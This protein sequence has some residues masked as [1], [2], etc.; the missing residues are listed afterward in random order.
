MLVHCVYFY[1][2]PEIT[3]AQRADFRRGLESLAGVKSAE[4]VYVGKP[5]DLPKRPVLDDTY[6]FG[7]TVIFKDTAGHNAYQTD[8]IHVAFLDKFRSY[9]TRVQVYDAD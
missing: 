5:A 1:L 3:E 2:K 8:P 7:L 4:K 9:W 6:S